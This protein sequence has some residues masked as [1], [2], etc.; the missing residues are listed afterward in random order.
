MFRKLRIAFLLYVL[1][2]VA[3]GTYF[4]RVRSTDWDDSLWVDVYAYTADAS[5]AADAYVDALDDDQLGPIETFFSEQAASYGVALDRP[6]RLRLAGR[7]PQPPPEPPQSGSWLGVAV[8]SLKARWFAFRL[9]WEND[10]PTP[11]IVLFA[12]YHETSG[13]PRLDS[14]TALRK[15]LIA[16]ANLYAARDM[17]GSNHVIVA[18]ELL[19]TVGAMDKYDP[20]TN[21]PLYPHGIAEPDREPLLPQRKAE[22][23]GGRIPL[24]PAELVIPKSLDQVVV[25]TTTAAEIGWPVSTAGQYVRTDTIISAERQVGTDGQPTEQDLYKDR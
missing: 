3:A 23:M 11:D 14:S 19:H 20:T 8:W 18:H 1:L 6:F 21:E 22:I 2:F 24:G 9:N 17:R 7:L 16:F 5:A 13:N 25:G 10:G 12:A 15:G 4:A